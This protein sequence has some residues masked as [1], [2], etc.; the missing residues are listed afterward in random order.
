MYMI[1]HENEMNLKF[2][3]LIKIVY[4]NNYLLNTKIL[5]QETPCIKHYYLQT[6]IQ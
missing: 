6:R 1:K 4:F 5:K 2:F 3:L